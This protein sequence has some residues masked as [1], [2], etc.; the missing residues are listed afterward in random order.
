[1]TVLLCAGLSKQRRPSSPN[2]EMVWISSTSTTHLQSVVVKAG[3][4]PIT[5]L[6]FPPAAT[7]SMS[8]KSQTIMSKASHTSK[9]ADGLLTQTLASTPGQLLTPKVGVPAMCERRSGGPA[10]GPGPLPLVPSATSPASGKWGTPC[11]CRWAWG[12]G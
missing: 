4:V 1:M 5:A 9:N 11:R 7:Q 10:P 3:R 2:I 8:S 12:Y 6:C